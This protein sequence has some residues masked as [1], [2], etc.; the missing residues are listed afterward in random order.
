MITST[1]YSNQLSSVDEF[2]E[3]LVQAMLLKVR[4][5]GVV[6][7]IVK[8]AQYDNP[9]GDIIDINSVL[10]ANQVQFLKDSGIGASTVSSSN[11]K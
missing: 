3:R 2:V 8:S 6:L 10:L 9:H 1:I 7:V 5:R 4:Q 11:K